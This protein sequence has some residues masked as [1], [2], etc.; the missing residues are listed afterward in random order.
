[1]GC[2]S[3]YADNGDRLLSQTR[4]ITTATVQSTSP[5]T[6]YGHWITTAAPIAQIGSVLTTRVHG[7]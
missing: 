5:L 1:M 3:L 2:N 4:S 6:C 7:P